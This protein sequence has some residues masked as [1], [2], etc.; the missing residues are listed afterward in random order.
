MGRLQIDWQENAE[1]LRQLYR[2]ERHPQRRT[3]LQVLW[4]LRSG[5]RIEDVANST[6]ISYR[7]IQNWVAWYRQGGL[8]RVL[9][10]VTGNGSRGRAAKLRPL[11]Q[12]ALAAK[13]RQG[14]FRS[15]WDAV[16]WVQAR[17]GIVYS[18]KGMYSLLKRLGG[19]PKVPRPR[20]DKAN[21][22]RQGAWKKGDW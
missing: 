3:R 2:R 7:A 9:E 20:S 1:E 15:A 16:G 21:P 6:G 14:T 8:L 13:V 12:Q 19:R 18:Y 4:Q 5:K 11:Q 10:R 17:W 22:T